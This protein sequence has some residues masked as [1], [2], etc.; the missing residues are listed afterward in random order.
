MPFKKGKVK[1]GGKKKGYV[2]Q[3]VKDIR[4]A[5]KMLIEN[6]LDNLTDW[7]QQVAK[8]NP[9]KAFEMITSLAEYHIPKLARMELTGKDGESIKQI[10]TVEIVHTT[11]SGTTPIK[12]KG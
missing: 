3:E 7:I 9:A 4:N 5:F 10:T 12:V 6:N 8:D 2:D 1:T 11:Q